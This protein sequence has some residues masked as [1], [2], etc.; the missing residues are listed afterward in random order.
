M[1]LQIQGNGQ[2]PIEVSEAAFGQ[3]YNEPLIHQAV[4][5]YL[6]GAR[7][8]SK[9]QK[10]RAAVRGGGRKPWRQ[11]G[12]G[13]ARAGSIR[14]PLW[15]GGG[16]IH[17]AAPRDHRVKLN[18]RM[19]RGAMRSLLSELAR[20]DRLVILEDFAIERP[21]TA[22]L[23]GRLREYG[24][25]DVLIVTAQTSEALLLASRNLKAVDVRAVRELDPVSL[26]AFDKVAVTVPALRELEKWLG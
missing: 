5:A 13:R 10:T 19:Y 22:E 11:K 26:I 6:A 24:L 23:A 17:A 1:E 21:K 20:R 4:T 18:R 9:A 25:V 12:T 3:A 16:K 2:K 7:A 14:S 15:R 8:G